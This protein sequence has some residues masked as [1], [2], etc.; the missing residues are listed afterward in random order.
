MAL[1]DTTYYNYSVRHR[2]RSRRLFKWQELCLSC[3]KIEEKAARKKKR[4]WE[5]LSL[6]SFPCDR[7]GNP[8]E[9][10]PRVAQT[11]KYTGI[12]RTMTYMQMAEIGDDGLPIN[13]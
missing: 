10:M 12:L 7:C 5:T 8:P 2:A 11:R 9:P 4:V 3:R 13:P 6:S 1:P